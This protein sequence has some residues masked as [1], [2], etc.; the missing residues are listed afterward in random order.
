MHDNNDRSPEESQA[1]ASHKTALL[2]E[3]SKEYQPITN[4][5]STTQ[6]SNGHGSGSAN[7]FPADSASEHPSQV[8]GLE[9]TSTNQ[10]MPTQS[11]SLAQQQDQ[12][13]SQAQ[14][15]AQAERNLQ[16]PARTTVGAK[17]RTAMATEAKAQKKAAAELRKKDKAEAK[18]QARA[19][20]QA[21][22]QAASIAPP[23]SGAPKLPIYMTD[24]T[25]VQAAP[26][27][28]AV[29]LPQPPPTNTNPTARNPP[30][31]GHDDT[32]LY[33]G[34]SGKGVIIPVR[35]PGGPLQSVSAARALESRQEPPHTVDSDPDWQAKLGSRR[36]YSLAQSISS[37]YSQ[38]GIES[39]FH[40]NGPQVPAVPGSYLDQ[41]NTT[42]VQQSVS[43]SSLQ[44]QQQGPT[45]S[46]SSASS[47]A[48][49][50]VTPAHPALPSFAPKN[51]SSLSN[52]VFP[53]QE[54]TAPAHAYTQQ[55]SLAQLYGVPSASNVEVRAP[56]PAPAGEHYATATSTSPSKNSSP[57]KPMEPGLA[58][59]Q[60]HS[61]SQ[62][63]GASSAPNLHIR[64]DA[65]N[66]FGD[67]F[68]NPRLME[69]MESLPVIHDSK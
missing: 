44:Q 30:L 53:P 61:Q 34:N 65:L 10:S 69:L 57:K 4:A 12:A 64:D 51:P 6:Q 58:Y 39:A 13:V 7:T 15:M 1:R 26:A 35:L 42:G 54:P 9:P 41:S 50:S 3:M 47:G 27:K 25:A 67:L 55:Q 14:A 22:A 56:A 38:P 18:A 20:A 59:A 32:V 46:S 21:N 29:R 17:S 19:L 37:I 5:Q 40:E 62:Q 2:L 52:I 36:N 43:M 49:A 33:H 45:S 60:Q 11:Q 31:A 66:P 68:A 63:Y 48:L 23:S 28:T 8:P 16:E 24:V